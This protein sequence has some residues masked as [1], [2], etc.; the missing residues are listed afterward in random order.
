MSIDDLR[1]RHG[2][3]SYPFSSFDDMQGALDRA[4]ERAVAPSGPLVY[5]LGPDDFLRAMQFRACAGKPPSNPRRWWLGGPDPYAG[6]EVELISRRPHRFKA[7]EL[8]F[9]EL[10]E[11]WCFAAGF[12]R[13]VQKAWVFFDED[14]RGPLLIAEIEGFGRFEFVVFAPHGNRFETAGWRLYG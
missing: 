11:V 3:S 14:K 6:M 5:G 13:F 7:T 8:D 9:D 1:R 10:L 4:H 12:I 2:G